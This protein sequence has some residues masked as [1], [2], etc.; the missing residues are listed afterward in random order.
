MSDDF[1]A[2]LAELQEL[3][4]DLFDFP[5]INGMSD[6]LAAAREASANGAPAPT[7]ARLPAAKAAP[8]RGQG[9]CGGP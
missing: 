7:P 9:S 1:E 5:D 6:L 8:A 4:E 3:D 2:R